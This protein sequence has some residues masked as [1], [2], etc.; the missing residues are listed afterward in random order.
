MGRRTWLSRPNGL[1]TSY[2]YDVAGQLKT[3][4][5]T[6]IGLWQYHYDAVGNRTQRSTPTGTH[7]YAYDATDRL[8]SATH[9]TGPV[10]TFTYDPVGN[11][12][13]DA[14]ASYSYDAAHRLLS[15]TGVSYTWDANGNLTTKT[16]KGKGKKGTTTTYHYD[17]DNRLVQ[18]TSGGSTLASFTYDPFG[19]RVSKTTS[20]GTVYFVYDGE[21][22]LAE[23]DAAGNLLTYYVHGPGID[24][25]LALIRGRQTN[26]YHADALGTITHLTKSTGAVVQSNKYDS[27]GNMTAQSGTITQPYTFTSREWDPETGLYYYRARY[28]DPQVG[29][30]ITEDP[31]NLNMVILANRNL[32]GTLTKKLLALMLSDPHTLPA[33]PYVGN[34]P[35]K[36]IDPTGKAWWVWLP[37]AIV[38]VVSAY[39]MKKILE[40]CE[41]AHPNHAVLGHPDNRKFWACVTQRLPIPIMGIGWGIDPIGSAAIEV[42][43]H[44]GQSQCGEGC[45]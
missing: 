3:I 6:G 19:R 43:G 13:T 36:Y 10:E 35:L 23:V 8:T 40:D 21:D 37:P 27:F 16:V 25:P 14:T 17:G 26:Y 32:S 22:I 28:Y 41:K 31:L 33:Y 42:G 15:K 44:V 5:H 2:T 12:L 34:N 45:E 4:D 18:V 7:T 39:C 29:R 20:A 9:P 38:G 1:N 11:R 30:F 24:E